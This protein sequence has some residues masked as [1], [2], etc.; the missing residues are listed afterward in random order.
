MTSRGPTAGHAALFKAGV[1]NQP[2]L[3]HAPAKQPGSCHMPA[4]VRAG[5]GRHFIHPPPVNV[6]FKVA[7][8]CGSCVDKWDAF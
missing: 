5:K 4:G 3:G 7:H 6:S 2:D 1:C 8:Y